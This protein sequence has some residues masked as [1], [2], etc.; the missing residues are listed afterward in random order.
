MISVKAVKIEDELASIMI[1]PP[2]KESENKSKVEIVV[3][4]IGNREKIYHQTII[5]TVTM[6]E[7]DRG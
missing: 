5:G 6:D 2:Y 1:D 4:Y 3:L 7:E